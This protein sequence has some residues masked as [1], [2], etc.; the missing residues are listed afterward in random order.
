MTL[1][2]EQKA[3][4]EADMIRSIYYG[5]VRLRER[6]HAEV[7]W[8]ASGD[9]SAPDVRNL[10]GYPA[11]FGQVY[12]LYEGDSCTITEEVAPGFFDDVLKDD[13]H[14]NYNHERPSAMCRNAPHMPE[15]SREGPG[16]MDISV[17]N[18]GLRVHARIPMDDLDAQR[19]APKMDR[20]VVD[21]MSY[22]FTVAEEDRLETMDEDGRYRVHYTLKK[23]R[24]LLDLAVC[25][26][27]ANAGTEV[28][29]RSLAGQL[30]GRSLEEGPPSEPSRAEDSAGPEAGEESRSD[31]EGSPAP[32]TTRA[33][34]ELEATRAFLA[35]QRARANS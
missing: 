1:T 29:L 6:N 23:A 3:A 28:A 11:V 18:H 30:M 17:D 5:D 4:L 8:R 22:A 16:S 32:D 2:R 15:G 10:T 25:P 31:P 12:T 14:L 9:P 27:G 24:R 13:C 7:K 26:L 35:A 33:T 19:L 34:A 20:G 21:Q